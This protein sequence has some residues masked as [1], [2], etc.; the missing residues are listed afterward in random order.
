MILDAEGDQRVEFVEA[1]EREGSRCASAIVQ[2]HPVARFARCPGDRSGR[3]VPPSG[4]SGSVDRPLRKPQRS[5]MRRAGFGWTVSDTR[6]WPQAPRWRAVS[7]KHQRPTE[8]AVL[9]PGSSANAE[10]SVDASTDASPDALGQE[11]HP[12]RAGIAAVRPR[13]RRRRHRT[14]G[15]T[16]RHR[17]AHPDAADGGRPRYRGGSHSATCSQ[18]PERALVVRDERSEVKRACRQGRV[19]VMRAHPSCAL[20]R[21]AQPRPASNSSDTIRGKP[22]CAAHGACRL[23]GCLNCTTLPSGSHPSRTTWPRKCHAPGVRR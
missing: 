4:G 10:R 18:R 23:P 5:Y 20:R 3:A 8:A 1:L 14:A 6:R 22:A 7:R 11:A 9:E 15:P 19:C 21:T 13:P 16:L 2:R 12:A 17:C